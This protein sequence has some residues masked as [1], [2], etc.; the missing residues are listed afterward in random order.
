MIS[1]IWV[2]LLK[3]NFRL[4]WKH[5]NWFYVLFRHALEEKLSLQ[6]ENIGDIAS[7]IGQLYY[8]Y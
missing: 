4:Y 7:K 1:Y 3:I 6:R 8:H 5:N 2:I